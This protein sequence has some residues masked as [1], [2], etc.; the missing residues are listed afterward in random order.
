VISR[1]R[2]LVSRQLSRPSGSAGRIVAVLM[3]RGN[4]RMNS[5]AIGLLDLKDGARVLDLGF[6]GGVALTMLLD[7]GAQVT[8]VDRAAAMVAAA[9]ARHRGAIAAGRLTVS[10]ADVTA[11]PMPANSVDAV[12]TINTIY[13]WPDLA[14]AL[15]EITRVLT[16]HGKL[17][18]GIR[19]G[20]VMNNVS[21]DIFT[22]RPPDE[23]KAKVV[24][25]GFDDARIDS[26]NGQKV[27][28]IVAQKSPTSHPAVG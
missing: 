12:L 3:N 14:A 15:A 28:Y 16:P 22:I 9:T 26:P 11:L 5:R 20:A 23:I 18:I 10:E 21:P 19:D 4:R 13:F 27:H 25:A 1:L 17:V 7:R 24:E 8:G 6:G 2:Q